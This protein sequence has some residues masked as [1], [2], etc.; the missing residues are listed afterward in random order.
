[1]RTGT[2]TQQGGAARAPAL[3]A[4]ARLVAAAAIPVEPV[5]ATRRPAAPA[6]EAPVAQEQAAQE[7]AA[8]EQAVQ[9]QAVQVTREVTWRHC[10][11]TTPPAEPAV[12]Q[13]AGPV[14]AAQMAGMVE[15]QVE[16]A[17]VAE[18]DLTG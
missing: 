16:P 2:A 12:R 11:A 4:Q 17:P 6:G 10:M 8:Q 18:S 1:V 7:Q 5:D 15:A 13:A 3:T 14:E 9:E